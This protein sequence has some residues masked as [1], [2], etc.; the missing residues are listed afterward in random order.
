L[1]RITNS[2]LAALSVAGLL[3]IAA[4]ALAAGNL[5]ANGEKLELKIDTTNLKF[6]QN[7]FD[8]ETGKYYRMDITADDGADNLVLMMPDF[9]RNVWVNQIVVNDLEVKAQ[10]PYSLEFDAAGTFNVSF[11]PIRPGEYEFYSPGYENKGLKGK[12]VVK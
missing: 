9:W 1:G 5:A 12:F 7:E 3:A 8:L 2:S 10:E 11:V 4:P 6:S